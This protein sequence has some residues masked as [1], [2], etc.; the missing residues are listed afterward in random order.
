MSAEG[1]LFLNAL[2]PAPSCTPCRSSLLSGRYFWQTGLGAIL[3]GTY[4]DD[5][6]PT[7]PLTLEADGYFIGHTYKVWSPGQTANAP[8]GAARTAY[9]PA[10]LDFNQFS[11]WVT[12]HQDEFDTAGGGIEAAKQ[13]MLAETRDNFRAFLNDRP[14]ER[15]FCYWWGPTT[16]TE[17][18]IV[19][20]ARRYGESTRT[21]S[22]VACPV[23][24][25]TT[26]ART[27]QTTSVSALQ[28]IRG[29]AC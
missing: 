9:N 26:S 20:R 18:G 4:W 6:I 28:W 27:P 1:A 16:P 15:P 14:A 17:P 21:I 23:F 13:A 22:G 10:G 5:A 7:F 3:A 12:A 8:M 2:V 11:H 25:S 24:T 19:A 29:S